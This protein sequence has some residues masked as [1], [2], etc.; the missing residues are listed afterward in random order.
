MF[1]SLFVALQRRLR[2]LL[3]PL[4]ERTHFLRSIWNTLIMRIKSAFGIRAK[5]RLPTPAAWL[6]AGAACTITLFQN[7]SPAVPMNS[8]EESFNQRMS[9]YSS[10]GGGSGGTSPLSPVG[11]GGGGVS[12]TQPG[13][14][15]GGGG[16]TTPVGGGGTGG[17]TPIDPGTGT[18]TPIGGGGSGGTGTNPGGSTGGNMN[19]TWVA[20]PEDR[21]LEEGET[22]TIAAY[23][24]KGA[25]VVT[26]Q[27]YKDGAAIQGQT[28]YIYRSYMSTTS[29]SGRYH[30]VASAGGQSIQSIQVTVR[31]KP[32]RNEC[33]AGRYSRSSIPGGAAAREYLHESIQLPF[34]QYYPISFPL[35]QDAYMVEAAV[36]DPSFINAIVPNAGYTCLSARGQ[37][38]CRNGKFVL[39]SGV[40]TQYYDSGGG[41]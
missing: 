28:G 38:Q 32:A 9:Q 12:P 13:T 15:T 8:E 25:D 29:A 21:T 35:Q 1:R 19:L 34:A 14:G 17:V 3:A 18:I 41:A 39:V 16:T 36:T 37:W 20:Q 22:L 7:C 33:K 2:Y 10:V 24:S 31:V 4:A 27:W 30:A 11:S 26:Y 40:C 6:L 5:F 23:A